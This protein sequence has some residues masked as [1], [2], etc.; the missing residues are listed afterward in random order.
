MRALSRQQRAALLSHLPVTNDE[1]TNMS[2]E[3]I[4]KYVFN[5]S[6]DRGR[7]RMQAH[8]NAERK[9]TATWNTISFTSG[10]NSLYDS[11]KSFK[12]STQGEMFRIAEMQIHKDETKTKVEADYLFNNLLRE[13]YGMAGIEMMQY[14][15]PNLVEAMFTNFPGNSGETVRITVAPEKK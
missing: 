3:E 15:V 5:F 2:G 11:L 8:T 7:N 10:N 14:I 9:N 13:N 4:S 12:A 1:I 6:F